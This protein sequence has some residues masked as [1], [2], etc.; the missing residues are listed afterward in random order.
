MV[1]NDIDRAPDKVQPVLSLVRGPLTGIQLPNRRG[2]WR[3]GGGF[4]QL[5]ALGS[6]FFDDRELLGP[7]AFLSIPDV[8]AQVEA[9]RIALTSERQKS[10]SRFVGEWRGLLAAIALQREYGFQ[11]TPDE[12]DF[13]LSNAPMAKVLAAHPPRSR[14][15]GRGPWHSIGLLR[16][17]KLS[18]RGSGVVVGMA[19]PNVIVVTAKS[20]RIQLAAQLDRWEITLPWLLPA[21][22]LGGMQP[23]ERHYFADPCD[24]RFAGRIGAPRFKLLEAYVAGLSAN[25]IG[26]DTPLA[27]QIKLRLDRFAQDAQRCAGGVRVRLAPKTLATLS[28]SVGLR[29]TFTIYEDDE[30]HRSDFQIALRDGLAEHFSGAVLIDAGLAKQLG[31]RAREWKVWKTYT[32]ADLQTDPGLARRIADQIKTD[33]DADDALRAKPFLPVIGDDLFTS[34]VVQID[35]K[36]LVAETGNLRNF[37]YPLT[38]LVLTLLDPAALRQAISVE[39]AGDRVTVK[40]SLQKAGGEGN[41]DLAREYRRGDGAAGKVIDKKLPEAIDLWPNLSMPGWTWNFGFFAGNTQLGNAVAVDGYASLSAI[42]SL[43]KAESPSRKAS[44]VERLASTLRTPRDGTGGSGG[45]DKVDL[46]P[47]DS[48]PGYRLEVHR[49]YEFPEAILLRSDRGESDGF[50]LTRPVRDLRSGNLPNSAVV[51]IDFGTTNTAVYSRI[52]QSEPAR[53]DLNRRYWSPRGDSLPPK[54]DEQGAILKVYNEFFPPSGREVPFLTALR[55]RTSRISGEPLKSV[56]VLAATVFLEPDA[57]RYIEEIVKLIPRLAQKTGGGGSETTLHFNLKWSSVSWDRRLNLYLSQ[58]VLQSIVELVYLNVSPAS[59]EWRFSYPEAFDPGK[60]KRF[61]EQTRDA[62]RGIYEALGDNLRPRDQNSRPALPAVTVDKESVSAA[63]YFVT[64]SDGRSDPGHVVTIDVGGGTADISI[65]HARRL[66]WRSSIELAGKA[67]LIDYIGR[68]SGILRDLLLAK[69]ETIANGQL[70]TVAALQDIE[71]Y[72]NA[73]EA[74]LN[75]RIGKDLFTAKHLMS[76]ESGMNLAQSGPVIVR[77]T[78]LAFGAILY[79]IGLAYRILRDQKDS[80][81]EPL[82]PISG[83]SDLQIYVG[84][85]ASLLIS[86]LFDDQD[87]KDDFLSLFKAA[88]SHAFATSAIKFSA[89]PKEEVAFG[90]VAGGD[91]WNNRYEAKDRA[92]SVAVP[93]GEVM[94]GALPASNGKQGPTAYADM[95][96]LDPNK[97]WLIPNLGGF[98]EFRKLCRRYL[99]LDVIL[100]NGAQTRILNVV[101]DNNEKQRKELLKALKEE[102]END[103][104]V[105]GAGVKDD[106]VALEPPFIRTVREVLRLNAEDSDASVLIEPYGEGAV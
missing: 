36:P 85:R 10:Y 48:P 97:P 77:R 8:W 56:P 88:S 71:S 99:H 20:Y 11:I 96:T 3:E 57:N 37:A 31:P 46:R 1:A 41:I 80:S 70:E 89:L 18:D 42:M 7:E 54:S 51:G 75:S 64:K 86:N 95:R 13:T 87:E 58:L 98:D 24:D 27:A 94:S 100:K 63:R 105:G 90:L 55:D 17:R 76:R 84:G 33:C 106:N 29:S 16:L 81:G 30:P 6:T 65:W 19:V 49:I 62:V 45:W 78:K 82:I 22:E 5:N 73:A 83:S 103:A 59:I 53:V 93:A 14:I 2:E 79:Y 4:Q 72:K 34:A 52:H 74:V 15:T 50:L 25:L 60:T 26:N 67:M 32:A 68:R 101:E 38:P 28:P 91:E 92:K 66:I 102:E 40:L 69:G 23:D 104:Q 47:S 44:A 9:Y 21:S 43:L 39:P 61:K 35:G 12:Y